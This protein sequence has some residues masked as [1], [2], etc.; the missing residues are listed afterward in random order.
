MGRLSKFMMID[1][2]DLLIDASG[3]RCRCRMSSNSTVNCQLNHLNEVAGVLGPEDFKL[4]VA[5][6]RY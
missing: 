5:S 4:S 2:I 3:M 6:N 1:L